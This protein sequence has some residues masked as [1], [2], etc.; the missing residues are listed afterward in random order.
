VREGERE[1]KRGMIFSTMRLQWD[2]M[3]IR[4]GREAK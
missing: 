1:K 3:N 2:V 4:E